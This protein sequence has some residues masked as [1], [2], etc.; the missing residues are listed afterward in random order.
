MH[1]ATAPTSYVPCVHRRWITARARTPLV[2]IVLAA[3]LALGACFDGG[4]D[5]APSPTALPP[6]AIE[7]IDPEIV[8]AAR[9]LSANAVINASQAAPAD[10]AAVDA[11]AVAVRTWLDSHLDDLQ[12]GG[13]GHLADVALEGL[14]AGADPALIDGV[15]SGLASPQDPVRGVG[16]DLEVGHDGAPKWVRARVAVTRHSGTTSGATFVF[17]P[18]DPGPVL[19]A[20]EPRGGAA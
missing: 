8:V 5:P 10:E 13:D 19:I 15:T 4:A 17:V 9:S 12:N 16:Y 6:P 3:S 2:A 7:P 18:G 20:L 11:L 1:G 14:L